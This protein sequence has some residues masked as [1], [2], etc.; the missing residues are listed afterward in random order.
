MMLSSSSNVRKE[1]NSSFYAHATRDSPNGLSPSVASFVMERSEEIRGGN[2]KREQVLKGLL[3]QRMAEANEVCLICP[4]FVLHQNAHHHH[5][6]HHHQRHKIKT[7]TTTTTIII[8]IT[9]TIITGN[10]QAK[11]RR[12]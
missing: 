6:H 2:E 7:T 11:E 1:F 8:T 3:Q 10:A 12:E 5:H 4:F 9:T